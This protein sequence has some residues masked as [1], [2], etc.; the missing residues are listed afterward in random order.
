MKLGDFLDALS[1]ERGERVKV[2]ARRAALTLMEIN[3]SRR[4]CVNTEMMTS[5][6]VTVSLSSSGNRLACVWINS[7]AAA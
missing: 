2:I 4:Y 5:C 1:T 7:F 6:P 3:L